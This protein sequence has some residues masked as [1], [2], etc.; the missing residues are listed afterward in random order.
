MTTR[1][2]KDDDLASVFGRALDHQLAKKGLAQADLASAIGASPSYVNR[3]MR[4]RKVSPQTADR[5]SDV[6]RLGPKERTS[7]HAAAAV[8]WGFKL[9][10]TP[11]PRKL[12]VEKKAN[13]G[14]PK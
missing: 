3:L 1:R 11:E 13:G 10:L 14:K 9:D 12:A 2:S 8:T 6:L 4:G 5:V 7:L